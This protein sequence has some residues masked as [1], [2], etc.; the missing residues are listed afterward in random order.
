MSNIVEKAR[1]AMARYKA[2]AT[3]FDDAVALTVPELFDQWKPDTYYK[4]GERRRRSGKLYKV[5]EGKAHTSRAN[6]PPELTPDLWVII[7]ETH[8]GTLDDPIPAAA[9]MEY[10]YGL[11]Y[12]DPEDGKTYLCS[13]AGELPGGS[14][15][16][17]YLPHELV[18][19]YFEE[20]V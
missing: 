1:E 15:V 18:G 20:V 5:R 6:W 4:E 19:M 3:H 12:L 11:Y 14:I 7:D 2:A 17:H 8:A 13:R 16:L 9:G 10:V